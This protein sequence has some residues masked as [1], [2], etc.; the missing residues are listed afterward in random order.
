MSKTSVAQFI[1]DKRR[2]GLPESEIIH[3]MLDAGWHMDIIQKTLNT[4][5][6]RHR[7]LEPILQIKK[8]PFRKPLIIIVILLLLVALFLVAAYI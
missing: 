7:N 2:E 5:P 8:Q 4:E 6:L 1:A 3:L